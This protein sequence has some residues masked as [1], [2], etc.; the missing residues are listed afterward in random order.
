MNPGNVEWKEVNGRAYALTGENRIA[1]V[2]IS[3]VCIGIELPGQ[4]RFL[5]DPGIPGVR[6]MGPS[7]SN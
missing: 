4:P 6:S 2:R 7:V 3:L 5:S 1:K